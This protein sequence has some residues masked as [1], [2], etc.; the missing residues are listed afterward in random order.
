MVHHAAQRLLGI[1]TCAKHLVVFA[2]GFRDSF[3]F[4]SFQEWR[5]ISVSSVQNS[6]CSSFLTEWRQ[7]SVC[8][9]CGPD[10]QCDHSWY[11]A[12][13]L[14]TRR[15]SAT[16]ALCLTNCGFRGGEDGQANPEASH[17]IRE[18][19]CCWQQ[20]RTTA[21]ADELN[22]DV[23][24]PFVCKYSHLFLCLRIFQQRPKYLKQLFCLSL[25]SPAGNH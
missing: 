19:P 1:R 14:L 5:L 6:W 21:G 18:Q 20:E 2:D 10:Q 16:A 3:I 24:S 22:S 8:S 17:S 25:A 7:I 4:L 9:L 13:V 23:T 15:V 11:V 12:P